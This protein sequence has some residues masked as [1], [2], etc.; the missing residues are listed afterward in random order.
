ME[1]EKVIMAKLKK[2]NVTLVLEIPF[3][4]EVTASNSEQAIDKSL[5]LAMTFLEQNTSSSRK[6]D[7]FWE[8]DV[9]YKVLDIEKER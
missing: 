1:E 6:F 7:K 2:Y 5:D 3:E 4:S 8:Y 9:K